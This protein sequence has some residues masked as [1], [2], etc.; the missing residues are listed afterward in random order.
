MS[1]PSQGNIRLFD[2]AADTDAVVTLWYSV[3]GYSA[4][5]HEPALVIAKKCEVN[6]GL[7]LVASLDDA[8]VGTV[9]AGY[10]GHRGWI[11]SLAVDP[12]HRRH[13]I[14]R[15]LVQAAEAALAQRGCLKVN[16][17]VVVGNDEAIPFYSALGYAIEPRISM[18][19]LLA[20][21]SEEKDGA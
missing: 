18:G 3:F 4:P 17:Q 1:P 10:D 9:M 21:R 5:H 20:V 12:A 2:R 14:G 13:G 8:V 7:F 16:L 19:R 11:Y 6:D 15:A